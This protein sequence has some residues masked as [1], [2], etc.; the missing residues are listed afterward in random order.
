LELHKKKAE[1]EFKRSV[2]GQDSP[3]E[4]RHVSA[5]LEK[6]AAKA[7]ASGI[8]VTLPNQKKLDEFNRMLAGFSPQETRE[9][10]RAKDGGPYEALSQRGCLVKANFENRLEIAKLNLAAAALSGKEK[11]AVLEAIR[12]G[13]LTGPITLASAQEKARKKIAKFMRRC[14]I[15]CIVS[16]RELVPG[17]EGGLDEVRMVISSRAVWVTGPVKEKLEENFRKTQQISTKVQLRNA[18]RQVRD[19]S[20]EEE[21]DFASLQREYL[22]LLKEQDELLRDFSEEENL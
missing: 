6:L 14:G 8:I 11:E 20:E 13:T 4:L 16:D 9:S 18:E 3:E 12:L 21:K 17:C 7:A 1:L 2:L 10:I 22:E 5:E 15:N 19:F